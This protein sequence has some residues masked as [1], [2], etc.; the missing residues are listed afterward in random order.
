MNSDGVNWMARLGFDLTRRILPLLLVCAGHSALQ[1]A[2]IE[3]NRDIRPILSDACYSCHG[4]DEQ[5]RVNELRLDQQAAAIADHGSG[6][7]VVPGDSAASQLIGRIK[8]ADPDQRMPPPDS[9]N[10]LSDRQIAT[11]E[12]W[13]DGGADWQQHWAFVAPVAWQPPESSAINWGNNSIDAFVLA[14]IGEHKLSPSPRA[15]RRSLIRRVTLDLTGIPPTPE[16]VHAFLKDDD[17]DAYSRVVDGLLAS[18]RYGER[19]A[20]DWLDAARYADTSG[21]QNDGPR[22]MWRWRDWVI[23]AFNRDMPFDQFTIEQLAGDL[24]PDPTLAQQIATG[25]NRNHRGNAEGGIIPEE[26]QVEYVADRVDTTATVWLGLTM[27]CARC[28]DHK[29]D[30]ISQTE[31]YRLYA[32]FNNIPEYGRAIKEGNSPPLIQAPTQQQQATLAA[33]RQQAAAAESSFYELRSQLQH[34]QSVWEREGVGEVPHD[35][36]ISDGLV[37]RFRLD[38]DAGRTFD[39]QGGVELGDV[40]NFG[41]FDKFTLSARIRPTD[42]TGTILSRMVPV[43][44]GSGYYVDLSGGHLQVNLVK[45]WLDDSIRVQSRRRLKLNGWQHVSVSYDG[46]RRAA[47]IAVYVDGKPIEMEVVLDGINQSFAVDEPF[48]IGTGQSGFS[49]QIADV[50]VFDR[51]L[52]PSEAAAVAVADSIAEIVAIDPDRRSRGQAEKLQRYFIEQQAAVEI[53]DAHRASIEARRRLAEFDESIPTVMVMQEKPTPATA[54][55][56]D[57]GRYDAP[58]EQ[59]Y[60][61]VPGVLIGLPEDAPDNRLGLARWIVSSDH[62]LTA[63]VAANR[64]WQMFFGTGLVK[65][66]EDFGAQGAMPSHPKLL[67][68]LACELVHSGWDIKHLQRLI[69]NSATYQQ[70]S[71]G[72]AGSRE[73]DP[74][75]RLLARGPRLRLTAEMVRDQAL[76]ASGLMSTRIGGPS[77]RPYQPEGLWKEIASTTNY[78]Q[79]QG[80]DLY[81]RSLYTYW[82][83]TV[84]P[85][86]MATFDATTREAC[87]VKRTRTNTPLQA[88]ALMNDVTFVEAA[89]VLAERLLGQGDAPDQTRIAAVFERV[90]G[91]LPRDS[92]A[93][94]LQQSLQNFR[95]AFAADPVAAS[96]LAS[97]GHSPRD[98]ALEVSQVAAWTALAS[99]LL[100]L[101]EVVTK[102]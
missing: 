62:P 41:Y 77:V 95:E 92:E 87:C 32:Y 28:H 85:P 65:T 16:E 57:R 68:W 47:G 27:G 64:L 59:V 58:G 93:A 81:R 51:V 66:G 54:F 86:T 11:L 82:K 50:L 63:R 19:M 56:L 89:R 7:A 39:G 24:L 75:N 33:L 45:R 8:S 79:S 36:T 40:G 88:L 31:F 15:D 69:V 46:S 55:V 72:S 43:E 71:N 73:V 101:D 26:Y 5:Q 25:F 34:Q 94:I 70:D 48:R 29:Y 74:E 42:A 91:R 12:A 80:A 9:G 4:P 38:R 13:I 44:Q 10:S 21:Y 52:N 3:F 78:E 53:R 6:A 97:A 84:A 35:W 83:R 102:E 1:A 14:T 30:P 61:G 90:T 23:E 76:A 96:R 37:D 49:G 20:V 60:P 17:G 2:E 100:N 99:I 67:D 18:P 98:P 22:E